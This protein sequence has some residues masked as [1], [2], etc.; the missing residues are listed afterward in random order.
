MQLQ[1]ELSSQKY[2]QM[3]VK[4]CYFSKKSMLLTD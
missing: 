4:S 2:I 3:K 1:V